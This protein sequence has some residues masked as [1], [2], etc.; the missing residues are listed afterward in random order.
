MRM[1]TSF[2]GSRGVRYPAPDVA[3]GFMLLLIAVA[4]V[5]SWNKMPNGAEPPVSSVDGWWMFVRTLLVDH[6]AY[7]LFAMLFGFGLMTM[8]NRRIASG[9]Q[10]YLASLP[11][12][13]E[14]R[15]FSAP[16]CC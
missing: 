7:P 3:R 2:T 1:T 13:P 11:G 16:I 10:T 6:R 4:N 12:A 15:A 14:G 5:P 8:I 9:T